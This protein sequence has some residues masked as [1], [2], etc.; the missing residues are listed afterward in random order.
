[1]SLGKALMKG[2]GV[3]KQNASLEQG[4]YRYL[5]QPRDP[6]P[7]P[8]QRKYFPTST[9]TKASQ[10]GG[11]GKGQTAAQMHDLELQIAQPPWASM[12]YQKLGENL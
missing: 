4:V 8:R 5:Q 6:Q 7:P 1:M 10:G 11:N 3:A 12:H 9:L 2:G